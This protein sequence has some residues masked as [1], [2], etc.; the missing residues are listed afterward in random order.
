MGPFLCVFSWEEG[1]KGGGRLNKV[2]L[3]VYATYLYHGH[4]LEQSL[5]MFFGEV[6]AGTAVGKG[7]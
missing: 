5:F 2:L 6:L 1:G 3:R 7:R 4:R